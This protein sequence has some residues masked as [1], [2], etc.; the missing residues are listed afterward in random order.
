MNLGQEHYG[1][2]SSANLPEEP[3]GLL[4]GPYAWDTPESSS[5][6]E[7]NKF[8]SA[9]KEVRSDTNTQMDTIILT[10]IGPDVS[11]VNPEPKLHDDALSAQEIVQLDDDSGSSQKGGREHLEVPGGSLQ[12]NDSSV[13]LTQIL[14]NPLSFEVESEL[15][16][17]HQQTLDNTGTLS[18]NEESHSGLSIK[19]H[20]TRRSKKPGDRLDRIQKF[21]ND[22]D[23]LKKQIPHI[24]EDLK[25]LK[26]PDT[27]GFSDQYKNIKAEIESALKEALKGKDSLFHRYA[28]FSPVYHD[29]RVAGEKKL[30]DSI[31][32][33][34]TL[35]E[36]LV[37]EYQKV[38]VKQ[39]EKLFSIETLEKTIDT[40]IQSCNDK[41][42][43]ASQ[44][45]RAILKQEIAY[46]L[47]SRSV[48]ISV[49]IKECQELEKE[50][51]ENKWIGIKWGDKVKNLESLSERLES[52]RKLTDCA[53]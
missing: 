42:K 44:G 1:E 7:T 50:Q 13:N 11:L 40:F 21:V 22:S 48:A 9:P 18:L 2:S 4:E 23:K 51:E 28:R 20:E 15:S 49:A 36:T 43:S 52:L 31:R 32:S 10:K 19:T 47:K 46:R 14:T 37:N 53:K 5:P 45:S 3:E 25:R 26:H 30:S 17:S 35:H 6:D 33:L 27:E 12:K 24:M 8:D 34:S 41:V 39:Q 29:E 38:I 16:L